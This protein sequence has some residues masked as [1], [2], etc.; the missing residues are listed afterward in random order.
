MRTRKATP[1]AEPG[2]PEAPAKLHSGH[3]RDRL[4]GTQAGAKKAWRNIAEHPLSAAFERGQ[5]SRGGETRA[6]KDRLNAGEFYRHLY[7]GAQ[8]RSR[9]STQFEVV[10]GGTGAGMGE[11]RA[12]A[13][14]KLIA[15]DSRM[16]GADR[17]IVRRV[18]GEGRRP[19]EAVREAL[20]PHYAK[21]V[22]PRF[23]EA[24]D[25]LCDAIETARKGRWRVTG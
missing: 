10:L 4:L 8:V 24:L 12:D 22:V 19:S 18:C 23:N 17:V 2:A 7:E 14:R 5:L 6:A 9:D 1:A 20:G 13:I 16:K 25:A 3:K 15:I 11:A 21:A